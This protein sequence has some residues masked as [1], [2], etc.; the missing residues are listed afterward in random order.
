VLGD[1]LEIAIT[2]EPL[3]EALEFYTRLGFL[4]LPVGDSPRAPNAALSNGS[5]T[6][7][8][9]A[10]S[11]EGPMPTFVRPELKAHLRALRRVGV[12]FDLVEVADD[13]FHRASFVDPNGQRALLVEARTFSPAAADP[14]RVSALGSFRE[15]SVSTHSADVSA[16]FWEGLGFEVI[17]RGDEPRPW[18]RLSGH[19]L[20]LAFH[21]GS[22]FGAA[23]AFTSTGLDARLAYLDALGLAAKRNAPIAA[24]GERAATLRGPGGIPI[25]LLEAP[26]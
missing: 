21:E 24:N 12:D 25:Y 20:V 15:L 5:L 13:E 17:A 6:L 16:R 2:A 19:G 3:V 22:N 4:S 10:A 1:L 9:H 18:C 26:R 7:G 14:G 11:V 8:L 23:L